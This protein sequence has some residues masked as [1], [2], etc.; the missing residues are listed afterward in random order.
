MET[1][2]IATVL[3]MLATLTVSQIAK[4]GGEESASPADKTYFD[5]QFT[6]LQKSVAEVKGDTAQTVSILGKVFQGTVPK[7]GTLIAL[8]NANGWNLIVLMGHNGISDPD[9]VATGTTFQYP[10]T[11]EEFQSALKKG[12]PLYDAWLAK[13]KTTFR[14]NRVKVDTAQIDELNVRVLNV[15]EKLKIK[16]MEVDT[17]RIRLAEVTEKLRIK[18][19][20]IGKATIDQLHIKQLEIDN[21]KDLCA[22]LR[23]RCA[24]M[25]ARPP[26]VQVQEKVVYRDAT[27]VLIATG[28]CKDIPWDATG[29]WENFPNGAVGTETQLRTETNNVH[30]KYK[31]VER[32]GGK[33]YAIKC[34]KSSDRLSLGDLSQRWGEK[35]T[36]FETYGNLGD[37]GRLATIEIGIV[38]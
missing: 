9:T 30:Y 14:V 38:R 17:L 3:V 35:I 5:Q 16:D 29:I 2:K 1:K 27:G 20:E 37:G 8:C 32:K 21:L 11:T 28:S 18:E 34:F 12:K 10:K 13:Q 19:L 33:I 4:A 31:L 15:T 36:T 25:E 7:N 22:Q 6:Q 23:A 26:V 24:Q